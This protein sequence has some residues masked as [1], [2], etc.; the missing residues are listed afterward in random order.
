[1]KRVH[2]YTIRSQYHP[3]NKASLTKNTSKSEKIVYEN[4]DFQK[5]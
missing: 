5:L 1:V 2:V 4:N 3:F